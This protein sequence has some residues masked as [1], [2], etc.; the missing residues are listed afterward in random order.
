MITVTGSVMAQSVSGSTPLPGVTL[1]VYRVSN[2]SAVI[3]MAT[4]DA[5]GHYAIT[6]PTNNQ[7]VDG[8]VKATMT[9]Y[10]DTYVYPPIALIAD[11]SGNDANLLDTTTY[12]L[13]RSFGGG[14]AGKGVIALAIQDAS[15]QGVAGATLST[16]PAS[17]VY[18]YSDA[19]GNPTGTSGTMA[20]GQA[21][22]FDAPPTGELTITAMKTGVTFKSHKLKARADVFTTTLV[23][24]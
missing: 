9:G 4:S 23:T 24:E 3:A 14:T 15:G 16:T 20:D 10:V 6:V 19:S 1:A 5:Q 18:K 8:Y 17:A 22:A 12:G 11:Y 13:L 2:D 21:F 7:P